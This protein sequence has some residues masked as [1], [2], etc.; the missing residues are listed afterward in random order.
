MRIEDLGVA[1]YA[2]G[3][4]IEKMKQMSRLPYIKGFTTNPT[5][6]KKAGVTDYAAFAKAALSEIP[7]RPVSMEVFADDFDGMER[8]AKEISSWGENVFV[9]IPVMNTCGEPSVPLIRK[10]SAEG[11]KLNVTAV[12]TIEQVRSVVDA[13]S[14][15]TE[16][17]VSV[18]A[19]RIL[20]AGVDA[21]QTMREALP[22]CR[23]KPGTKL[24]WASVRE[25]FNIV[26]ADRC[27]TDIITVPDEIIAKFK[28]FG[29]DL[30]KF[31]Q[32]TVEMFVNDG[33][34]LGFSILPAPEKQYAQ[35]L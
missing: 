33:R 24:L 28:N 8:E 12:F 1:I 22:I 4:N 34:S 5:L 2:D 16:N 29:K 3:A 15:G 17:I 26:Q 31:S 18:F 30:T 19:G 23:S 27:G 25:V 13:F 7:D 9:K 35:R 21:E 14:E 10:L 32:E 11:L 20:D 6:M